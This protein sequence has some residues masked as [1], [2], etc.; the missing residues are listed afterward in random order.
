MINQSIH[1]SIF[2][3][4][5]IEIPWLCRFLFS[6]V[7]LFT[8]FSALSNCHYLC[9]AL[10]SEKDFM[11]VFESFLSSTGC[12]SLTL[13]ASCTV[14]CAQISVAILQEPVYGDCV[15][16]CVRTC[17]FVFVFACKHVCGCVLGRTCTHAGDFVKSVFIPLYVDTCLHIYSLT[18]AVP[19]L[20]PVLND[21]L[22]L[23]M[24]SV[25]CFQL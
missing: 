20:L 18:Q 23:A 7:I 14:P 4:L 8:K 13:H 1:Q 21:D 10:V 2:F 16:A 15:C 6:T 24:G 12:F 19:R 17:V 5:L 25:N 3:L 22:P 9:H 11:H